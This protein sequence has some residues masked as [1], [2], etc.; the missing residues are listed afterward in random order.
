ML[1]HHSTFHELKM[2]RAGIDDKEC[3]VSLIGYPI[4][5][6]EIDQTSDDMLHQLI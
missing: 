2:D 5:P 3:K 4:V 1:S 6:G